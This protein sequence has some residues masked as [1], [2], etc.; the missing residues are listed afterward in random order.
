MYERRLNFRMA[1]KDLP[2]WQAE[3]SIKQS[4][5]KFSGELNTD[6]LIIGGGLAGATTAFLLCG[7]GKKVALVE[8]D[9]IG[10]STTGY[11]TAHITAVLDTNFSKLI[12]LYGKEKVEKIW[13]AGMVAI[14]KIEEITKKHNIECEFSRCP[15]FIFA[16][17]ENQTKEVK[18]DEVAANSIGIKTTERDDISFKNYGHYVVENQ[19]KFQPLKYLK[20]LFEKMVDCGTFIYEKS[21]VFDIKKIGE[22]YEAKVGKGR[23]I[24]REV[25]I[26]TY[27]PLFSEGFS[28]PK[29]SEY[30]SYVLEL[31]VAKNILL[32]GLYWDKNNPYNYIRVDKQERFDRV[33]LGGQ[34]HKNFLKLDPKKAYK[35]LEDYFKSILPDVKYK[36]KR[37]WQGPILESGDGLAYIG[38]V[39]GENKYIGTAF[40][41]NG[42]VYATI[43]GVV[44]S[45]LIK[46]KLNPLQV[47]F[48]PNRTPSLKQLG[49]KGLD[50][51]EEFIQGGVKTSLTK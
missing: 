40:S 13:D 44:V 9:I 1:K 21:E 32:E 35:S 3:V 36:I 41:G 25:V 30:F 47:I 42:M 17:D 20:G 37:R 26:S 6:V 28:F 50:Y 8:K 16:A 46:G 49:S 31:E 45:D 4:F 7:S 33:I 19:A 14:D 2:T 10:H 11:T 51:V 22:K 12:D 39:E 23:I 5:P 34:D 48:D 43:F 27:Y 29:I 18:E 15:A 38:K 24:A